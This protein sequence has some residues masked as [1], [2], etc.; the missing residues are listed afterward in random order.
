MGKRHPLI[1]ESIEAVPLNYSFQL[2]VTSLFSTNVSVE[3]MYRE[4]D[5]A[6]PDPATSHLPVTPLAR[7]QVVT[8]EK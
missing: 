7:I 2:A 6:G 3:E 1:F 4:T 5:S 8:K